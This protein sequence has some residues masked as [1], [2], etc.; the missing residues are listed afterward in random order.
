MAYRYKQICSLDE[1]HRNEQICAVYENPLHNTTGTKTDEQILKALFDQQG[2]KCKLVVW[3]NDDNEDYY[4]YIDSH[5][6]LRENTTKP[7]NVVNFE[8]FKKSAEEKDKGYT[9]FS[10]AVL[11]SLCE[12]EPNAED[13]AIQI[14]G[15][16][17]I[18]KPVVSATLNRNTN[19]FTLL[20]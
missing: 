2:H 11:D 4:Q 12:D 6:R 3:R 7:I 5:G 8:D 19:T 14:E 18:P 20:I 16:D 15:S 17:G 9:Y 13:I 1:A 10:K